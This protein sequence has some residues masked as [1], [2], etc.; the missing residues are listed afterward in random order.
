MEN[1]K[2]NRRN[3]S[4]KKIGDRWSQLAE[5]FEL[6]ISQHRKTI[7]VLRQTVKIFKENSE[8]GLPWPVKETEESRS[9][10]VTF[11]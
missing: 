5:E 3:E 10:G 6:R 2:I 1:T 7:K 9:S 11:E 4:I 8:Q